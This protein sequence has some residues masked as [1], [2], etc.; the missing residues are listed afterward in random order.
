MAALTDVSDWTP[1]LVP[2]ERRPPQREILT[3]TIKK[4]GGGAF[5]SPRKAL[6]EHLYGLHLSLTQGRGPVVVDPKYAT[7]QLPPLKEGRVE[8]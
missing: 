1:H 7:L 3:L 5:T 2:T 6:G 8:R 4:Q